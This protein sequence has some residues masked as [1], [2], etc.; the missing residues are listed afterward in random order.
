MQTFI[1]L[2]FEL[3]WNKNNEHFQLQRKIFIVTFWLGSNMS[4]K[5]HDIYQ[6][7][8]SWPTRLIKL[9]QTSFSQN[10]ST[11]SKPTHLKPNRLGFHISKT[12]IRSGSNKVQTGNHLDM[13]HSPKSL[14]EF[15][16]L[17]PNADSKLEI[18]STSPCS[19]LN[20]CGRWIWN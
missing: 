5:F 13:S 20:E 17:K 8:L 14:E 19:T 4:K 10:N 12:R 6:Q 11:L 18:V 2:S 3:K 7:P 9:L 16:K 15:F 1:L